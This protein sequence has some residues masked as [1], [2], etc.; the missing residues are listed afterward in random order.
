MKSV[1]IMLLFVFLYRAADTHTQLYINF[2]PLDCFESDK[3]H[4]NLHKLK[5]KFIVNLR[6][7]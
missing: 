7:S 1:G 5:I 2:D 4:P 6:I 3:N